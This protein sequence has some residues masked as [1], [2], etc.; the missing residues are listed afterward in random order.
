LY[1]FQ[2]NSFGAAIL[3]SAL[4]MGV[5]GVF[6]IA[7]VACIEFSWNFAAKHFGYMPSI[8]PWQA[9]LVYLAFAT[10][11][12]LLGWFRIEIKAGTWE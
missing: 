10:V 6:V 3:L 4:F 1:S 5:L 12:Y 7:P 8:N 11:V 9:I 2:I